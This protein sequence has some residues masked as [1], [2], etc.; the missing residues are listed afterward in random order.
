[1]THQAE[2]NLPNFNTLTRFG[3]ANCLCYV[4]ISSR[5]IAL[6]FANKALDAMSLVSTVGTWEKGQGRPDHVRKMSFV[7]SSS[8]S[9]SQKISR[10]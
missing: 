3:L 2:N 8:R 10:V 5:N 6:Y 1:M 4:K 9:A 7:N